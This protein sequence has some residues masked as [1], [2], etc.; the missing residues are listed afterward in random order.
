MF[1]LKRILNFRKTLFEEKKFE[2][3][4]AAYVKWFDMI[5]WLCDMAD[6]GNSYFQI[7][8]EID[9]QFLLN[10]FKIGNEIP[11]QE[12]CDKFSFY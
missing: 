12:V 2:I 3:V 7:I 5:E 4:R 11:C 10:F 1:Y 6:Y 8:L 9:S